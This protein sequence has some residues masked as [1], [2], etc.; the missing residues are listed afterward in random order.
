MGAM[1]F[2]RRLVGTAADTVGRV[3]RFV[4]RVIGRFGRFVVL[5]LVAGFA[6]KFLVQVA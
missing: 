3:G 6:W 2:L 5:A 1:R 4:R